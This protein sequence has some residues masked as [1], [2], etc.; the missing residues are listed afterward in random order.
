MAW[1]GWCGRRSKSAYAIECLTAPA[2][3]RAFS[4]AGGV[5]ESRAGERRRSSSGALCVGGRK[6]GVYG[7]R[8][9]WE[10]CSNPPL[11]LKTRAPTR[12][13]N[14]PR[15]GYNALGQSR[16]LWKVYRSKATIA[17]ERRFLTDARGPPG[18]AFW[19][20]FRLAVVHRM[21]ERVA[22]RVEGRLGAPT[23]P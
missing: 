4:L 21:A 7:N 12:G 11:V 22:A 14:T 16:S 10:L 19:S 3:L 20:A 18:A 23:S 13:A 15:D 1:N 9:H 2:R 5:R 6:S 17:R 8:T